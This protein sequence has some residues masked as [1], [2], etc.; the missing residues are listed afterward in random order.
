[1]RLLVGLGNPGKD[2]RLNRHNIGF[3]A[4]DVIADRYRFSP[5]RARFQGEGHGGDLGSQGA[6]SSGRLRV[7]V[8]AL[9]PNDLY[10]PLGPGRGRSRAVLQDRAGRHV[11]VIYD[12]IELAPGKVK[13]KLGGGSAGH[14]GIKSLD[15]HIGTNYW[16]VR[17]GVGRPETKEQVTNHVLDDF[18]KA[19]TVWL[20]PLLD[21]VADAIP[22][23][24]GGD[25]NRFMTKIA[26]LTKPRFAERRPTAEKANRRSPIG[27]GIAMDFN[28]GIVGL[29]NVGKSTLFNALTATAAAQAA[30]FPFCTIEPNVGRVA[31][32]DD[33]LDI[34]ARPSP[35]PPRSFR[36]SSNSSI[37]P[38][39]CAAPARVKASAT[40]SWPTSARWTPSS[41]CCAVSSTTTSPMWRTSIDPLRDALRP[42]IPN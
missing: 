13:V 18:A 37:S 8:L 22:L 5:W 36:R 42:S 7:K 10:E 31:M 39:W 28:C 1:M 23:L 24:V 30:N 6:A 25:D 29:P 33:R 12:E 38:A 20:R 27:D 21:A 35:N 9:K 2:Y 41:T 4:L 14:N 19:D 16:R 34:M 3:M 15:E 32:P 26:L 17:L 40:S 11:I